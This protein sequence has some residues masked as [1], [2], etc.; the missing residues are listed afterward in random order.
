MTELLY[1]GPK[2]APLTLV[3]AHGAGAA[4]DSPFMNRI[5][6]GVSASSIRVV[7]FEFPYMSAQRRTHKRSA[8]DR[9]PVLRAT[10]ME[11]IEQLGGPGGLVIGGK[12]MGGRI[13]SM[14]AD[15]A[16]AMGLVCLGYPFHPPGRPQRLR[17]EHLRE[18]RTPALIVQGSRDSLGSR[19]EVTAY[20]LSPRV[21]V[22]WIEDGDHSFKPTKRSGRTL[23]QNMEEAIALVSGFIAHLRR[24]GKSM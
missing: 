20:E 14:I 24:S 4:M 9:E 3:L 13:A 22:A 2:G 19:D 6:A 10:W 5:A 8:P 1:D 7:R 21:R 23:E 15:E 18:L 17:V 11:V 16:G 12:S